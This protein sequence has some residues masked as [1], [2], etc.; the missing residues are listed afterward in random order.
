MVKHSGSCEEPAKV[1]CRQQRELSGPG[2]SS[3]TIL[4]EMS[5]LKVARETSLAEG[6]LTELRKF[7]SMEEVG[8][9]GLQPQVCLAGDRVARG[10]A[11]ELLHGECCSSVKRRLVLWVMLLCTTMLLW[12]LHQAS[13]LPGVLL[14]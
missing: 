13:S 1:R 5:K 2:L 12:L 7:R 14:H 10:K 11:A 6:T 8:L 4:L 9:S 3:I